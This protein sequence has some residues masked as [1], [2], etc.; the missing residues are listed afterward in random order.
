[1]IRKP[2]G[3]YIKVV[4][5][6]T[7]NEQYYKVSRNAAYMIRKSRPQ[8]RGVITSSSDR[9]A[10]LRALL[11]DGVINFFQSCQHPSAQIIYRDFNHKMPDVLI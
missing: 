10:E 9:L 11:P 4:D 8:I 1:M 2:N 3:Y 5:C 6:S 7:L